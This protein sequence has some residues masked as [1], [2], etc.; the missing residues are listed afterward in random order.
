M[1]LNIG[2]MK[3][4]FE[5]RRQQVIHRRC[6]NQKEKERAHSF[7]KQR[8]KRECKQRQRRDVIGRKAEKDADHVR[9]RAAPFHAHHDLPF[10]MLARRHVKTQR[11]EEKEFRH[12]HMRQFMLE[13]GET[14]QKALSE[15]QP[16]R[17]KRES[18][19]AEQLDCGGKR[20]NIG[21]KFEDFPHVAD[22]K[23]D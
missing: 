23:R 6:A 1:F 19:I 9:E 17:E 21:R 16:D 11:F 4:E 20:R 5:H 7:W 18:A 13:H 15:Q 3:A 22:G 8:E 10:D 12:Q 14:V 2:L